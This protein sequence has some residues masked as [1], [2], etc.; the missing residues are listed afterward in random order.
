MGIGGGK[1]LVIAAL[2]RIN[3]GAHAIAEHEGPDIRENRENEDDD[4][5]R[6]RV[7]DAFLRKIVD[8]F[9]ERAL[10][11]PLN[12]ERPVTALRSPLFTTIKQQP[13]G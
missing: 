1:K 4:V 2:M 3:I 12:K 6:I 5:H 8:P 13:G 10:G 11:N 7:H 9:R